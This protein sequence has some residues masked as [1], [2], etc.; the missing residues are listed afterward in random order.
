MPIL[1]AEIPGWLQTA[2]QCLIA[3]AAQSLLELN[4][5]IGFRVA[6]QEDGFCYFC[7]LLLSNHDDIWFGKVSTQCLLSTDF[8]FN[9][10]LGKSSTQSRSISE[11]T[12]EGRH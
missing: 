9:F 12:S 8:I 10:L 3:S 7:T 1:P 2:A 11:S 5:Y 4:F 6:E